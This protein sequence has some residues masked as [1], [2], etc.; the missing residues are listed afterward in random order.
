MFLC[1]I[2]TRRPL[3]GVLAASPQPPTPSSLPTL[4]TAPPKVKEL[5]ESVNEWY[6]DIFQ[7]EKVSE[8]R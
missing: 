7:L 3:L 8:K 2:E 1:I 6:F 4:A 5:L